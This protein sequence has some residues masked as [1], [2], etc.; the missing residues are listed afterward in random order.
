MEL[1]GAVNL[2]LNLA[3]VLMWVRWREAMILSASRTGGGT[4]LGTLK[5]AT[6]AQTSRWSW[7]GMVAALVVVR[8]LGY[9]QMG[10]AVRWT[11]SIDLGAIVIS[12]RSDLL[13]RM[14]WFSLSS[15]AVFIAEFYFCLFLLSAVNRRVSDSDP[16]QSRVRA[17]LSRL[18]RL[19]AGLMLL[20]PFLLTGLV[21]V[22]L[23]QLLPEL[24]YPMPKCT[25][26]QTLQQAPIF[27]LAG[28][29]AWK[30]LITGLL[31][32]HLVSSYVFLGN[33]PFWAFVNVTSRNLLRPLAWLP[34]RLGRIDLAPLAGAALVLFLGEMAV[35]GLPWLYERL[36]HP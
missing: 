30:Y 36:L 25:L 7:L 28:F 29:I 32:L 14:L 26:K 31:V 27:G 13:G 3:G 21:W 20:L 12:F 23:G 33:A 4:L 18:E 8:A 22:G 9:W 6:S 11:P 17:H 1:L 5:R 34:L 16:I 19:P 15:L 24:G 10:S 35:R 2:I